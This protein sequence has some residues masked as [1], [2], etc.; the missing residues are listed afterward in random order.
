MLL[1]VHAV[2]YLSIATDSG[3]IPSQYDHSECIT[4]VESKTLLAQ[5]QQNQALKEINK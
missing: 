5:S 2:F 3:Q 4:A 1:A